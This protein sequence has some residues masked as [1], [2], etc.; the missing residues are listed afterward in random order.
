V[1]DLEHAP[2]ELALMIIHGL[3][4][5]GT[6]LLPYRSAFLKHGLELR[7]L[8]QAYPFNAFT[9]WG[10]QP[11]QQVH[12]GANSNYFLRVYSPEQRAEWERRLAGIDFEALLRLISGFCQGHYD[13][14]IRSC[15]LYGGYLYGVTA[16]PDDLDVMVV[17][18]DSQVIEKNQILKCSDMD[19][20]I[21]YS[22]RPKSRIELNLTGIGQI[23]ARTRNNSVLRAAIISSTTAVRIVG[24]PYQVN[25]VPVAVLLYHAV[26]MVTWGFKL[27]FE[28]STS[29]HERAIW[30]LVEAFH[31]LMHIN[32][33]VDGPLPDRFPLV[34]SLVGHLS[35][36]KPM[37]RP[38]MDIF[39]ATVNQFRRDVFVL[40]TVLRGLAIDVLDRV[41]G[42]GGA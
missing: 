2:Q 21:Q 37:P 17:L 35:G 23:N 14:S 27:F 39:E 12:S 28:E 11:G 8:L 29:A 41:I 3:E 40:K 19:R 32:S 15:L 13:R 10:L 24:P 1:A 6:S 34:H 36:K 33:V 4:G 7:Q 18:D 16:E 22:R 5:K 30:R 26:E 31:I 25:P 9:N 42:S 38:P 20:I